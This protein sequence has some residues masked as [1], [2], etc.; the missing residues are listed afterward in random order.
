VSGSGDK[1]LRVWSYD[2]GE[3]RWADSGV[4][5]IVVHIVISDANHHD[6]DYRVYVMSYRR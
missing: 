2:E 1:T 6:C 4:F 3:C 5:Y